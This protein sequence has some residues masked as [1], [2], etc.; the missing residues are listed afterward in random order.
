MT[1][2]CGVWD[3]QLASSLL[4]IHLNHHYVRTQ[5]H[6]MLEN[7]FSASAALKPSERCSKHLSRFV[8]YTTFYLFCV[9]YLG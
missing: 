9:T 8:P 2:G 7:Q 6:F 5:R 3:Y 1:S 4:A